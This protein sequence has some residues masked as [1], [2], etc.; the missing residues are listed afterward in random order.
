MVDYIVN[1]F[2]IKVDKVFSIGFWLFEVFSLC[3]Y[4]DDR[5]IYKFGDLWIYC[6]EDLYY[7]IF[8]DGFIYWDSCFNCYYVKLE[9]VFDIIIGDF[10]GLGNEIDD[11]YIFKYLYGIFC[12]FFFIEK[13][14][15]FILI[16]KDKLNIY[17]CLVMEVING[18]D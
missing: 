8:I 5:L 12:V 4:N 18:N 3:V 2:K 16:V 11:N 14:K 15:R 10:W 9:R 7:N 17:E 13:G 1:I 6:Y